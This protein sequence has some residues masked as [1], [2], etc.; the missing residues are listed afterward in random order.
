MLIH[1]TAQV[2]PLGL[3]MSQRSAL[4][5]LPVISQW[6]TSEWEFAFSEKVMIHS[7]VT[8]TNRALCFCILM[9]G[10][11][12]QVQLYFCSN[13]VWSCR[14]NNTAMFGLFINQTHFSEFERRKRRTAQFQKPNIYIVA[15]VILFTCSMQK[16]ITN[17]LFDTG[18]HN[19]H[20]T[21]SLYSCFQPWCFLLLLL[22]IWTAPHI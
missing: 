14:P 2:D 20:V 9:I 15:V 10:W 12:Q 1:S 6:D 4:D 18:L 11:E 3:L 22:K 21:V 19:G 8:K 16:Q 17:A 5:G 7:P 13:R